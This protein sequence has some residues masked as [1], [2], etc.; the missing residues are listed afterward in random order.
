MD[1]VSGEHIVFSGHPSWRSI[2][3]FYLKGLLLAVLLGAVGWFAIGHGIGIGIGVGVF[4]LALVV[5]LL[6]RIT[7]T[8]AITNQRLEIRRGLLARHVQEARLE[9]V[10]NFNTDQSLLQ[11]L[12]RVGTVNF[13]TAGAGDADF[14]FR[15]VARPEE[16]VRAVN[17]AQHEA[18]TADAL[19]AQATGAP[20]PPPAP[21]A[22]L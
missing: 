7:T 19:A 8:Y 2:I 17:N 6:K 4:A 16:V 13:D 1:L 15:G 5:G 11:R 12:L 3:G 21:N 10:Q 14:A 22:G 9:R 18:K 20:P